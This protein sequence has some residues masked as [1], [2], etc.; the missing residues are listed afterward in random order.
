[1]HSFMRGIID[2]QPLI[3]FRAECKAGRKVAMEFAFLEELVMGFGANTKNQ[4]IARMR[5]ML[6][7]SLCHEL[8]ILF[9][10][11]TIITCNNWR[12]ANEFIRFYEGRQIGARF[13]A[14]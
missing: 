7:I 9:T 4:S 3:R 10:A 6:R 14:A 11:I 2:L 5:R 13:T 12:N 8:N 1:M